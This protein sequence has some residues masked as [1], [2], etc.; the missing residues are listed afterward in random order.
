MQKFE[1]QIT[2]FYT[3]LASVPGE[4]GDKRF[5]CIVLNMNGA[6]VFDLLESTVNNR[7]T[8]LKRRKRNRSPNCSSVKFAH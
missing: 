1:G 4:I 2:V 8:L 6:M 5:N 7:N 3:G